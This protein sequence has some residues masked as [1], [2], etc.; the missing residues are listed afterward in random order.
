MTQRAY[1]YRELCGLLADAGFV[2]MVG[3]GG[4]NDE[5]FGFGAKRL[6]L[7]ATKSAP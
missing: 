4:L 2:D 3:Y 5:P 6:L 1:T 7:V